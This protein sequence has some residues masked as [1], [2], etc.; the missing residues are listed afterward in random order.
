MPRTEHMAPKISNQTIAYDGWTQIIR[1]RV[2]LDDGKEV[3]REV[4]DHGRAAAV[5]PYD[6]VRRTALMVRV[7][8]APVLL[9]AGAPDL[10]EAPAGMVDMDENDPADTARREAY[11][12]VGVRLNKLEHVGRT[13]SLPG[14]STEQ[15]DLFLAP[16]RAADRD[17]PGGGKPGEN[18]NLTVVEM[19]LAVLWSMVERKEIE[20]IKTLTLLLMLRTRHPQLFDT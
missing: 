3:Q 11:E 7:L 19:T 4:E 18:E 20:D 10:L 8:R 6:P 5:L 1:V 9:A 17:G 16:Y 14:L 12:E 15:I 13:W 2:R